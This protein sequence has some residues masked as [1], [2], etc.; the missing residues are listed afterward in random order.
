[1]EGD[2]A[3]QKPLNS[4]FTGDLRT[5]FPSAYLAKPPTACSHHPRM[6]W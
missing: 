3:Q 5:P 6:D 2:G 1:M 4:V